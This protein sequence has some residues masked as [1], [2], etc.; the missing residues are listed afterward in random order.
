MKDIEKLVD[1]N[2]LARLAAASGEAAMSL[3]DE[4]AQQRGATRRK[5][6]Y[7]QH[8]QHDYG[9]NLEEQ[10]EESNGVLLTQT[11]YSSVNNYLNV[12]VIRIIN[13]SKFNAAVTVNF[14]GENFISSE[15][16][17][18]TRQV[19]IGHQAEVTLLSCE[20]ASLRRGDSDSAWSWS[21]TWSWDT[22]SREGVE[23]D[24][25]EGVPIPRRYLPD[26]G[27]SAATARQIV[28]RAH[29]AS[30]QVSAPIVNIYLYL[31]RITQSFNVIQQ[32]QLEG[33]PDIVWLR[34][35]AGRLRLR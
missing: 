31:A 19:A 20:C 17:Q 14:S 23:S 22:Y 2:K 33:P 15:G 1:R 26:E 3:E 35:R 5:D 16:N 6:D 4:I 13:K 8:E 29:T 25:D 12:T 28:A 11:K 27:M 18:V 7:G 30:A 9:Q 32:L 34:D 10:K 21:R 24:T